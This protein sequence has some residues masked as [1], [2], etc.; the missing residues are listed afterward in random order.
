MARSEFADLEFGAPMNKLNA[1]YWD[2]GLSMLGDDH[3]VDPFGKGFNSI[4][5]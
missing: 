2:E 3:I 5:D 4:V 1:K